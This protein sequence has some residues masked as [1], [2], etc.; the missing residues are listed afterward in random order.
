MDSY[1]RNS[2]LYRRKG[3]LKRVSEFLMTHP[4]LPKRI[5]ALKLFAESEPYYQARELKAP[6]NSITKK[7]LTNSVENIIAVLGEE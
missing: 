3:T 1:V 2:K 7:E 6:M 4:P 5:E